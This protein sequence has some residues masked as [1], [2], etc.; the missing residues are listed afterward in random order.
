M[1]PDAEY[2][3]AAERFTRAL[4]E[5]RAMK[6]K[7]GLYHLNQILMA[8]N[9][10][11]IEGSLLDEEQTRFIYETRTVSGDAVRVNDVVETMNSFELFDVM[12]DGYNRPITAAT[13]K[14]YHRILK[15]GTADARLDWFAIGDWKRVANVVGTTRTTPP[16]DVESAVADLL[17]SV[18]GVGEMSFA[19]ICDFHHRFESIHPFQDGNGRV[20]RIVLFQQCLQNGVMPFIVLD[21]QKAFYYRGLAEYETAP[22][23]L[24]D[25]FRSFQDAYF[26]RFAEF[27]PP[28][29]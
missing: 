10:N 7:G 6:L 19:D 17:N 20:G 12:I 16:G 9:T 21:A 24:R 27:L 18:P 29:G 26:A 15:S 3:L 13:L 2:P 28:S 8:Y 22:G 4:C 25:T 1:A 23:F 14:E 11:R 5:Q